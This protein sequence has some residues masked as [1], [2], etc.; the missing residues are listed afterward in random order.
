MEKADLQA[1]LESP[2]ESLRQM[3]ALLAW[4]QLKQSE[5]KP[6]QPA[7]FH[8][9]DPTETELRNEYS[10]FL[11]TAVKIHHALNHGPVSLSDKARHTIKRQLTKI[12]L[13]VYGLHLHQRFWR[14]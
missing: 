11:S 8:I 10:Y 7:A 2:R 5:A 3:K 12:E 14:C 13:E 1:E 9:H 6:G 4:E